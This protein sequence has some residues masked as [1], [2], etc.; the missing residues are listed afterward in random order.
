MPRFEVKQDENGIAVV[1]NDRAKPGPSWKLNAAR[2]DVIRFWPTFQKQVPDCPT[3]G[4]TPEPLN[5]ISQADIDKA[6]AMCN[7]L[8]QE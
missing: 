4:H 8:N 6:A 2:A 5:C 1:D 3:C 7:V